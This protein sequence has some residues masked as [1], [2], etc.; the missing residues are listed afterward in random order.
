MERL[1]AS[2]E[3]LGFAPVQTYIQ[4]GNVVFKA[5][6]IAPRSCGKKIESAI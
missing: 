3:G 1:R 6:K 4:S 5:R 2:F